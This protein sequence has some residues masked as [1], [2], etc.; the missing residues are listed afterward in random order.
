[1]KIHLPYVKAYKSRNKYYTYYRRSGLEQRIRSS[2]GTPEWQ[3]E[4]NRIH[5]SFETGAIDTGFYKGSVGWLIG[6]YIASHDFKRLAEET[7]KDYLRTLDVFKE[8][9]GKQDWSKITP[10]YCVKLRDKN[11]DV[12]S[13]ANKYLSMISVLGARA[14]LFGLAEK[15][16]SEH[17]K[18]LRLGVGK[19]AWK[20]EELLRFEAECDNEP[21][22]T[23]YYLALYT[24]Q[25]RSDVL[26]MQWGMIEQDVMMVKQNK[27]GEQLWIPLHPILKE[28][29]TTLEKTSTFIVPTRT[30]TAYTGDGFETSWRRQIQKI[31]IAGTKD[32]PQCTFH[33]LRRNAAVALQEAGCTDSEIMAITGHRT[34]AMVRLYTRD[35]RQKKLA[36]NAVK[37]LKK[38]K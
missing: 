28:Y 20:P 36:E 13:R 21:I 22:L 14:V 16:P 12:P 38:K 7:K 15:V 33:G 9:I 32:N 8:K 31:G 6:D 17:V 2:F 25:R 35:A 10:E 11:S 34:S 5:L 4:Y 1:M 26:S 30:G 18:K 19:R 23:A 3:E 29:L 24:G 27:T 37:K